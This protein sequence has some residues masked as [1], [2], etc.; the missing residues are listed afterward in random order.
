MRSNSRSLRM[1]LQYELILAHVVVTL[2]A[3]L[4]AEVIV[5]RAVAWIAPQPTASFHLALVVVCAAVPGLLLGA[6]ASRSVVRRVGRALEIS[7]AW[8][9]G[10]LSLRIAD[11]VSDDLGLLASQPERPPGNRHRG[12]GG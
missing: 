8:L 12:R 11:P 10:N 5:L 1:K 9:R 2:A 6:W 4:I 7:Q 3:I